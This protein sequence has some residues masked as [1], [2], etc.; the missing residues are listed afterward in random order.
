VVMVMFQNQILFKNAEDYLVSGRVQMYGDSLRQ[1]T[2]EWIL[3]KG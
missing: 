3:V 1:S 2:G